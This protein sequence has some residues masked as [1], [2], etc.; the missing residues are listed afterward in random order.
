MKVI[1]IGRMNEGNDVVINDPLVSRHHFQIVQD[2]DG[3]FRLADFGS[4]N[5]TYINGKR[6]KGEVDLDEND[7]IRVGNTI[8][9]WKR[10]FSDDFSGFSSS[11]VPPVSSSPAQTGEVKN[12]RGGSIVGR[13]I[14]I[15]ISLVMIIGG[16]SGELVLRGTNSSTALV[17][18]GV[19]LLVFEIVMLAAS[20]Q[21]K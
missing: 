13:I 12:N 17:I 1:T 7:I 16:L 3:R 18:V 14:G 19:L 21:N 10:Y 9:P 6:V 20:N 5:G 2:D 8:I 4:T 11:A 15:G